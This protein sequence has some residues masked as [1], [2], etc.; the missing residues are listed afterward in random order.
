MET[1]FQ[2]KTRDHSPF[3]CKKEIERRKQLE[4]E[5]LKRF[6]PE[7]VWEKVLKM[8]DEKP[9]GSL[10]RFNR[11]Q[12]ARE[13]KEA[14]Y[15]DGESRLPGRSEPAA[16]RCGSM[17]GTV[18]F[19]NPKAK[20]MTKFEPADKSRGSQGAGPVEPKTGLPRGS[21]E[22]SPETVAEMLRT[23]NQLLQAV[24]QLL[25]RG[26]EF[27]GSREEGEQVKRVKRVKDRVDSILETL[28]LLCLLLLTSTP[29]YLGAS[30]EELEHRL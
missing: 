2:S 29:L 28:D 5:R 3:S 25:Q 10:R 27:Q 1:C 8:F 14:L 16:K 13:A 20:R 18:S 24:L 22:I 26:P 30:L 12:R 21:C 17:W 6:A 4:A 7:S 19:W 11:K 9:G 23:S 15:N